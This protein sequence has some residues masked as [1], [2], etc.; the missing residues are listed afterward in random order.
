MKRSLARVMVVVILG[1]IVLSGCQYLLDLDKK[2]IDKQNI[3]DTK[4]EITSTIPE[5][6]Q[7]AKDAMSGKICAHDPVT[8]P[9]AH[10]ASPSCN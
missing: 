5:T 4:Q 7:S 10:A 1:S 2:R 9:E 8:E 3:K 6:S